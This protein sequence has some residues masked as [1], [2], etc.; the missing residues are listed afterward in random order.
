VHPRERKQERR[1]PATLPET[2]SASASI[3]LKKTKKALNFNE[4]KNLNQILL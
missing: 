4:E 1:D 3:Y 2:A